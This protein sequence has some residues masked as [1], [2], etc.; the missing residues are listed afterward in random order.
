MSTTRITID[1]PP[2]PVARRIEDLSEQEL[3]ELEQSRIAEE[4]RQ[5]NDLLPDD[6][7]EK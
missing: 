7:L 6:W 4:S 2:D 1:P 3:N 5:L